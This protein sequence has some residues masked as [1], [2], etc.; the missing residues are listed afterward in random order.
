METEI[1]LYSASFLDG[2]DIGASDGSIGKCHDFLFDDNAWIVRYLVVNT[3]NWLLGRKVLISPNSVNKIDVVTHILNIDLLKEQVKNSPP[4]DSD[5]PVSRQYEVFFNR[6]YNWPDYWGGSEILGQ[7]AHPHTLESS[8]KELLEIEASG[9]KISNL[10]STKEVSGY[11]VHARD[12]EI[13][14]V[15]DFLIDK[16]SWCIR[17]LVIDTS[18]W[19]ADG[20]R[21]V[22]HP[23]WVESV[24]WAE[25]SLEMKMTREQIESCPEYDSNIPVHRD[26]EKS[27]FDHFKLPYY[28]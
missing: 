9:E 27:I 3:R 16:N 10:R 13:G 12:E 20:K 22:V 8:E 18:K 14:H 2:F 23:N 28:W 24:D 4:L 26:F 15:E 1:N 7:A 17:Y 11:K 6:Y 25:G 5:A 21:V 19:I